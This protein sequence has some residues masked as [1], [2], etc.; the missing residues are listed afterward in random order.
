M[1]RRIISRV[2]FFAVPI[3]S[4]LFIFS[5]TAFAEWHTFTIPGDKGQIGSTVDAKIT[6]DVGEISLGAYSIALRFDPSAIQIED[7]ESANVPEFPN[8]PIANI[9][10]E[11]GKAVFNNLQTISL[12]S[13]VGEIDIAVVKI[14]IIGENPSILLSIR[15]VASTSR[16]KLDL[17]NECIALQFNY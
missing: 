4:I 16:E 2:G 10:N 12:T 8:A 15:T 11:A 14:K 17:D 5:S 6:L 7:I 13:P 9:D 1:C 3:L